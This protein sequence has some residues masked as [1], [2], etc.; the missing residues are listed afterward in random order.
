[1]GAIVLNHIG[2]NSAVRSVS[3]N[4]I[5]EWTQAQHASQFLQLLNS[6]CSALKH[7][8][9]HAVA[10]WCVFN[11]NGVLWKKLYQAL[12]THLHQF[13]VSFTAFTGFADSKEKGT[14]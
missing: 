1:M 8:T 4:F 12:A 3:T 9:V 10:Q 14:S 5:H 6:V 11:N 13:I 7:V 2:V